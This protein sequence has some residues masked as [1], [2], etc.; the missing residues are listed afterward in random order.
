MEYVY[1]VYGEILEWDTHEIYNFGIYTE[2]RLRKNVW[3]RLKIQTL[4]VINFTGLKK[5]N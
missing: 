2:E 3:T 4:S 1:V 5:Y